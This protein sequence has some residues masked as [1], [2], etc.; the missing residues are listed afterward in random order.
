MNDE[1]GR[2]K[3]ILG[4]LEISSIR[5]LWLVI[6]VTLVAFVLSWFPT[7]A[8]LEP[9]GRVT[10]FIL[11]LA[12]GLWVTEAIPTFAVALLVIGLEI[13]I[14][15]RPGGVYAIDS[16]DWLQFVRPWSSP[17]IWLFFGGFVLAE[18]ASKTGL[19]RW[20]STLVLQRC[21]TR[22]ASILLGIMGITFCFSMFVSN[23]ATTAMMMAVISPIVLSIKKQNPFRT[24]LLLC[25]PFAANLGG[26]G[27]V[28][29]SP[30]NAI[31]VGMLRMHQPID[32]L[33]WMFYGLPPALA[34]AGLVWF[35]LL[36]RYPSTETTLPMDAI[37]PT[38]TKGPSAPLWQKG[39]VMATFFTTIALWLAEPIHQ[40]PTPVIS[41]IPIIIF[42]VFSILGRDEIRRLP[43]EILLLLTGG[44][45]LGVAVTKTGLAAWLALQIPDGMES[46]LITAACLAYL[47]SALSNFMS[48]TAAANILI[49]I[50]M[51][52]GIGM[53][54]NYVVPLALAA[55]SAMCLPVSTPPNAIAYSYGQ[56]ASKDFIV[57]G[58]LVGLL[59]PGV[60]VLW[61]KWLTDSF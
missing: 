28:I 11:L 2:A 51:A 30:P 46:P 1:R 54:I 37:D 41:F 47:C 53:E 19:D 9:A 7:Y 3:E 29:G 31:A 43:W 26:M 60:C 10:L 13:A 38:S 23:T 5:P 52:L 24:A 57:G 58:L 32:F 17:I 49:P 27:T 4:I 36:K 8:G 44:L 25:V 16:D 40:I 55:S 15:G 42:T 22:P 33:D 50:G 14:L 56:L 18:A 48:N 59:A 35:F 39:L 34:L 45:A 61:C 6:A 12:G 20:F 21:G